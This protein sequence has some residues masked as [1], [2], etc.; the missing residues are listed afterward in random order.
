MYRVKPQAL[1]VASKRTRNP[2]F[3][4]ASTVTVAAFATTKTA[5]CHQDSG[6]QT[7]AEHLKEHVQEFTNQVLELA[8]SPYGPNE[9]GQGRGSSSSSSYGG[10][11]RGQR[12]HGSSFF[13]SASQRAH[14]GLHGFG[15]RSSEGGAEESSRGEN[16]G[17]RSHRHSFGGFGSR[18]SEGGVKESLGGKHGGEYSQRRPFGGFGGG[19]AAGHME[20]FRGAYVEEPLIPALFYITLAGLTGTIIAH[21]S[22]FVF[23]FL[24]PV[25]LALGASAYCIPRT[26]NNVLTGLRTYDYGELNREWKHWWL[27]TK[28]SVV[29]STHALQSGLGSVAHTAKDATHDLSEKTHEL[30]D[31]TQKVLHDVKDKTVEV[32]HDL[33]DKTEGVAHDIKNKTEDLAQDIKNQSYKSKYL[34]DQFENAQGQAK[35]AIEDKAGQARHWWNSEKR[36]AERSAHDLKR[37]AQEKGEQARDWFRDEARGRGGW[38]RG[39]FERGMDKFKSKARQDWEEGQEKLH[40]G[41]REFDRWNPADAAEEMRHEFGGVKD[42]AQ[43][44]GRQTSRDLRGRFEDAKDAGQD[45]FEDRGRDMKRFGREQEDRFEDV[46]HQFKKHGQEARDFGEDRFRDARRDIRNRAE[47]LQDHGRRAFHKFEHDFEEGD[48][49]RFRDHSWGFGG[50]PGEDD[51]RRGGRFE[52]RDEYRGRDG[53]FGGDRYDSEPRRSVTEAAQ[54]AKHWWQ[55]K[56]SAAD[57]YE[58]FDRRSSSQER[59]PSSPWWKAGGG[60]KDIEDE[61]HRGAD[62]FKDSV[63]HKAHQGH[64]WIQDRRDEMKRML[65]H[66]EHFEGKFG[67]GG[68]FDQGRD[69]GMGG[70]NLASIYSNDNW[71]HYDQGEDNRASRRSGRDRAM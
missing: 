27:H 53:R 14:G 9:G 50:R 23:R 29:S 41:R 16:G 46:R 3:L 55:Q 62:R 37:S 44:W 17:E 4:I 61:I 40:Q 54:E 6:I 49:S 58:S 67:R 33:K 64:N 2:A 43:S 21:K 7:E 20:R 35:A 36:H 26:T 32:A 69:F 24:S 65:E 42:R 25:A 70:N 68:P 57:P 59:P 56:T 19:Q 11:G 15:F 48:R 52:D 1:A 51:G 47:D 22:N 63:E 34:G 12:G 60:P 5:L 13:S 39:D 8:E 18:D 71:F 66:P 28:D 38:D 31:K 45:W 30:T 10:H